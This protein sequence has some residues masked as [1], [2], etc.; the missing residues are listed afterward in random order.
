MA[1]IA[2]PSCCVITTWVTGRRISA[3]PGNR[4]PGGA[5]S[6]SILACGAGMEA[7]IVRLEIRRRQRTAQPQRLLELVVPG[8]N[9]AGISAAE[10]LLGALALDEPFALE[11]AGNHLSPWLAVR[12]TGDT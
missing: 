4:C 9:E 10:G 7:T 5:G 8:R 1:G 2:S 12:T 11:I 6:P 3:I